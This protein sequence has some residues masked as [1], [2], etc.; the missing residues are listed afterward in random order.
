MPAWVET[1]CK[2]YLKR[3]PRELGV[4]FV[5]LP[6]ATRAKNVSIEKCKQEESA[7]LLAAVPPGSR[8]VALDVRGKSLSTEKLA[9]KLETW[10]MEGRDVCIF[11]GGPDG[12]SEACLQAADERWSLSAMTLPH[13]MV[14][15]IMSEQLYRAWTILAN[16]PYHK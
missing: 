4:H 14:R 9:E 6:L 10:Q 8:V 13:P 12:M 2:E 15:V 16:H 1:A 11:I 3:L 7:S 5:E